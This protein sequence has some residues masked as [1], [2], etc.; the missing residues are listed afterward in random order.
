MS[1]SMGGRIA[2]GLRVIGPIVIVY[3]VFGLIVEAGVP[4][5]F[6]ENAFT[7]TVSEPPGPAYLPSG[8]I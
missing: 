8:S 7:T 1:S 4:R 5:L 6:P 3:C 2:R